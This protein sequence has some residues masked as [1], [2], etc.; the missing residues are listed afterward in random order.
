MNLPRWV[1]F[2]VAAWVILFGGYRIFIAFRSKEKDERERRRGGMW[3]MP[4]R[5]HFLVG[6]I[7]LILGTFL[8][9]SAVGWRP[10]KF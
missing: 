10:F 9:L 3:G 1:V 4:R 5:T 2:L 7:Y 8:I 6:T